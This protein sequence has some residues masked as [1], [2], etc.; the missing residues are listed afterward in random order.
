MSINIRK[1]NGSL[2]PLNIDNINKQ[3][4]PA[5][6]GLNG[7][8]YENL[9]LDA[10]IMF[11]DG[12]SSSDVQEALIKTCKNK[13]DIDVP[14]WTFA[15]ARLTLYDLYHNM[16]R[17]Y[18]V[19]EQRGQVYDAITLAKY[20]DM[21]KDNLAYSVIVGHVDYV[22]VDVEELNA[23]IAPDRDK[24]FNLIGIETLIERYLLRK[25]NIVSELPQHLFMSL[26]IFLSKY[27]VNPTETAKEFYD[28]LS[29]FEVMMATPTLSNGRRKGKSCFSCFVGHTPD[30][31]EGIFAT[32][33]EQALYSKFGGGIGWSWSAV[34]AL[35]GIIQ[36]KPGA[37]GGKIPWLKIENDVA[38]AVN[39]LGVRAGAIN[40]YIETWDLDVF[41]FLDL[42][43]TSG[44][45]RRRAHDLFISLS[46]NSLFIERCKQD[47][48]WTLFDPY[49]CKDLTEIHG[50][51]FRISYENYEKT[52]ESNPEYF[53]NPPKVIKAKQLMRALMTRY[54]ESGM[55]F[56]FFKDN[57]NSKHEHPDE[58]I[59]RSS[60]L[61]TEILQPTDED[62]TVTCNLASINLAVVNT[63]EHAAKVVPIAMRMLDNVI[64]VSS[65]PTEKARKT[66]HH[67]RSIGLGTMG[68]GEWIATSKVM[69]G[70]HTHKEMAYELYDAIYYYAAEASRALAVEKGPWKPGKDFRNAYWG[71]IA[72]TSSISILV[73]TTASHEPVFKRKFQE[74]NMMGVCPV[75]APKLSPENYE[76]YV[77]AY[78]VNQFDMIDLT[79]IRQQALNRYG[80]GQSISHNIYVIPEKTE[81]K[82][83]YDLIL[84]AH[85]S[86]LMTTYYLRSKSQKE[87]VEKETKES[88]SSNIACSG[89]E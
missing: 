16:K 65:Y 60:N 87:K 18:N 57:V 25:N 41:D 5:C 48:N 62:R 4:I 17:F 28:V 89:C 43:K 33:A 76:Y 14:N 69:Y 50:E 1:R 20:L 75:V 34:R 12:M 52:L 23:Y 11:V 82:N 66:H 53:T 81:M 70:S 59:I 3:A 45:D 72:P 6:E 51:E 83:I 77:S 63:R 22:A 71:A 10:N 80:G 88:M 78:D 55:P 32:Y 44:E 35:G 85:D 84:Y 68:E 21:N 42:K 67:T 40:C 36:D 24:Q 46:V 73:G 9:L 58:G 56:L 8:S 30:T 7:I 39:Q 38:L 61:C 64:D 37:S 79:A 31:I 29:K 19:S 47:A 27:E 54:F 49:D 13:I 15:G 2:E 26:A 86:G 74:E